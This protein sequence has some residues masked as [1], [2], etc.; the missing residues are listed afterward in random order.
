MVKRTFNRIC[1]F[2]KRHLKT[3]EKVKYVYPLPL[4][5][6]AHIQEGAYACLTCHPGV[7]EEL[8]TEG[9]LLK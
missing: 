9:Q 1:C 3:G 8:Q 6:K 5:Y 7:V 2:C 4:K